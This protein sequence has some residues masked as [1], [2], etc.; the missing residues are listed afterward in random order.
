LALHDNG[1]ST[2]GEAHD[3][4]TKVHQIAVKQDTL[5]VMSKI[6]STA[7]GSS[8]VRWTVLLQALAD[9]GLAATPGAGSA[10]S[11]TNEH[12][13]ISIHQPHDRD[14]PVFNAVRLRGLGRRLGKWF[15]WTSETFVLREKDDQKS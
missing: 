6:F 12:G 14:G 13:T 10:M 11:F 9:A 15:G 1:V 5:S 8:G 3:A 7:D 2:G 4:L